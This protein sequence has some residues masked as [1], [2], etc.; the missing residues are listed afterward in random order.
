MGG[1]EE[2]GTGFSDLKAATR[3]SVP[4]MARDETERSE[5]RFKRGGEREWISNG[6]YVSRCGHV[7]MTYKDGTSKGSTGRRGLVAT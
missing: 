3:M 5:M 7:I 1:S 2:T 6:L 4:D